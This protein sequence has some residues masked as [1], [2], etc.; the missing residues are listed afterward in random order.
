MSFTRELRLATTYIE[1]AINDV[2][3]LSVN[4]AFLNTVFKTPKDTGLAANSWFVVIGVGAGNEI[5]V[6]DTAG[7]DSVNR[8]QT[9]ISGLVFG[10]IV[11]LYNNLWYINRLEDGYSQQAP[12]GM[13]KTTVA[14]WPQ[15][16]ARNSLGKV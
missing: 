11:T 9:A 3:R 13:V 2:W 10:G 14:D 16:V 12:E 4:E 8:V 1:G 7:Q 5:G 15:I 6:A